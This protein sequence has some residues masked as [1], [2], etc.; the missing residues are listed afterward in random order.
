MSSSD[1]SACVGSFKV[2]VDKVGANN[3]TLLLLDFADLGTFVEWA[4]S[5]TALG[6]TVANLGDAAFL[7]PEKADP[8]SMLC[9]RYGDRALRVACGTS[10]QD[11]GPDKLRSIAEMIM[12]RMR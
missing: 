7:G 6:E 9:V 5:R 8:Y 1:T 3:E 12:T 4:G 10:G 2:V 11:I